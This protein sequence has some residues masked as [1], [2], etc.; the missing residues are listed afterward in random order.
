MS[1]TIRRIA[2]HPLTHTLTL[3]AALAGCTVATPTKPATDGESRTSVA[4]PKLTKAGVA[5]T[6]DE[7]AALRGKTPA[8]LAAMG[9]T[10]AEIDALQKSAL[11][12]AN[13]QAAAGAQGGAAGQQAGANA[14]AQAGA[15][16]TNAQ[17]GATGANGGAT[18]TTDVTAA[19]T[20]QREAAE[21]QVASFLKD[22]VPMKVEAAKGGVYRSADGNVIA[23]IPPNALSGDTTVKIA[24]LDTSTFS[25]PHVLMPGIRFA[26]DLED[27]RVN[28]DFAINVKAKC[29]PRT[30]AE[31]Q[32]RDPAFTPEKYSLSQEAGVWYMQMPVKGPASQSATA[33]AEP[34]TLDQW[35]LMEFGNLPLPENPDGAKKYDL[36]LTWAQQ[37]FEANYNRPAPNNMNEWFAYEHAG[38]FGCGP[39]ESTCWGWQLLHEMGWG[40]QPCPNRQPD[41]PPVVVANIPTRT[42]FTSDDPTVNGQPAA[43]ATVRFTMPSAPQNGPGEVVADANGNATSFAPVGGTVTTN[44]YIALGP[45]TG[46]AAQATIAQNMGVINLT[47]E[48]NSPKVNFTFK[49]D[50]PMGSSLT[51]KYT[52]D[53][54]PRSAVVT[55]PVSGQE[56]AGGT[57][58]VDVPT[59]GFHKFV[60]TDVTG[61]GVLYK[62]ADPADLQVRRNGFYDTSVVLSITA[63][64]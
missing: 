26:I 53:G 19:Q 46:P 58:K 15:A 37:Q 6:A 42:T 5:L 12:T 13:G 30:I 36:K 4:A 35:M 24:A 16:G 21:A 34:M 11:T 2:R 45:R 56:T 7:V 10:A 64:K 55:L 57:V 48:K 60:V 1:S 54:T 31:L 8:E 14:G 52:L 29:D 50:G 49:A 17:P 38:V 39:I 63:P 59:D 32:K 40:V 62:G 43:G 28:P 44:S 25:V 20:A 61:D 33:P 27:A 41:T 22:A 3:M 23:T 47:V 18:T 51:V 9:M